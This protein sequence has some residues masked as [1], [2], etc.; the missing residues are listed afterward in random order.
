MRESAERDFSR[1]TDAGRSLE[2]AAAFA[3]PELLRMGNIRQSDH[4]RLRCIA[5]ELAGLTKI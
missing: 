1:R 5:Q 2:R 4:L 3:C